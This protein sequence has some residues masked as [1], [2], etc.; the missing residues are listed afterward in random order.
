MAL[1]QG[2]PLREVLAMLGEP[3]S[4][5]LGGSQWSY[6]PSW[7]R[8]ECDEVI[9][10]YSSPLHPLR[11]SKPRPTGDEATIAAAAGTRR[12]PPGSTAATGHIR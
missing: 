12:C 1:R 5:E 4:R 3:V 8:F 9:D 11:A 10:W 2:M 6:G 7:V